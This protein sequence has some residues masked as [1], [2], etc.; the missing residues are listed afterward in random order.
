[1]VQQLDM[2]SQ[3]SDQELTLGHSGESAKFWQ[4][5]HQGTPKTTFSE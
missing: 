2:G 4:L 5:D 3:F 1:M